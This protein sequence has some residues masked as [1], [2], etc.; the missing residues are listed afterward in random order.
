[1]YHFIL[2]IHLFTAF[3]LLVFVIMYFATGYMMIHDHWFGKAKPS[4]AVRT[5]SID[6]PAGATDETV[7]RYLQDRFDL[8]GKRNPVTRKSDG[9]RQF[10]FFRPG[11]TFETVVSP[12]GRSVTITQ[13]EFG[14]V[15]L[16]SSLHRL[17]GYGGGGIYELWVVLYDLAS[18]SLIVFAL[19][20]ILLW[21]QSTTR[22]LA[23]WICLG[24]GV[25]FTTAMILQLLLRK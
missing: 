15:A 11:T 25:G 22:H 5:E 1:M 4:T 10:N 24:L 3:V 12:D 20:G 13:K 18:V 21:Y 9:S 16:A 14:G 6:P 7:S 17:R 8:R 2:R 23:G 19:S